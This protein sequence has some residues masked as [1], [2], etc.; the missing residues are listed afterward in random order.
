MEKGLDFSLVDDVEEPFQGL[1]DILLEYRVVIPNTE[2]GYQ[3][4]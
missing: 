4:Q 3:L 2:S 1:A